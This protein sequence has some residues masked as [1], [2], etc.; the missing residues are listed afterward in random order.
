MAM[1]KCMLSVLLL[2]TVAAT[3]PVPS[4]PLGT[5]G[6][7]TILAKTGITTATASTITGDI[8]VSPIS[9]TAITGFSLVLD[10][11]GRFST[12]EQ[13]APPGKAYASDYISPTPGEMTTAI[14]DMETAYRNAAGR[15]VS[16]TTK[17]QDFQDLKGGLVSGETLKPGVYNW[18]TDINFDNRGIFIEG[19]STDVFIFQTTGSVVAAAGAQVNLI[20]ADRGSDDKPLAKN[21]FWQVAGKVTAG[22]TSHL[23]GVF[24]VSTNAA[25][26]TGSSVNGRILAQTACTLD[27]STIKKPVE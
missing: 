24:L 1:F 4:V 26:E 23:E 2:A 14:S 11:S 6:D 3:D 5:A 15:P 19:T 21:I 25:L 13:I 18:G 20:S 8:G 27:A 16:V 12:S 7:F 10:T 9:S 17:K 22:T